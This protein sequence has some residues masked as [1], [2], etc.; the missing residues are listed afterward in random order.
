MFWSGKN[1]PVLR[2]M[3]LY[4]IFPFLKILRILVAAHKRNVNQTNHLVQ[5]SHS[6]HVVSGD[7][8]LHYDVQQTV[9]GAHVLIRGRGDDGVKMLFNFSCTLAKDLDHVI[10]HKRLQNPK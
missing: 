5:Q 2:E 6:R 4:I 1:F 8:R 3:L 7:A 10:W 9:N